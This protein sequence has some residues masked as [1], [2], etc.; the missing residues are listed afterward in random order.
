[1]QSLQKQVGARV[2]ELR[3]KKGLSQEALAA[4]CDLHRT[5]VGLIERGQRNLSLT[6]IQQIA[7]GLGVPAA[8]LFT[9]LDS[10]LAAASRPP[11]AKTVRSV[12]IQDVAAHCEVIRQILIDANLTDAR[13]YDAQ[14]RA[15]LRKNAGGPL[16]G[17]T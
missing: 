14:H 9:G 15:I 17:R 2:R 10:A 16:K 3:E 11:K 1:M 6:A 7:E 13:R 5:Y 4:V 8:D 12:G